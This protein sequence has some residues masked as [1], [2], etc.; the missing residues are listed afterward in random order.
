MYIVHLEVQVSSMSWGSRCPADR[1]FIIICA[2]IQILNLC[3]HYTVDTQYASST[4]RKQTRKWE[5][6][7]KGTQLPHIPLEEIFKEVVF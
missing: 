3:T 7:E 6:P 2:E 5:E 1:Y 4:P